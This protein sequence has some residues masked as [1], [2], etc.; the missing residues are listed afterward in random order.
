MR[1]MRAIRLVAA[2]AL[3]GAGI[4]LVLDLWKS[5]TSLEMKIVWDRAIEGALIGAAA[6]ALAVAVFGWRARLFRVR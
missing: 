3:V 1:I 6:G 2:G 5:T 4:G